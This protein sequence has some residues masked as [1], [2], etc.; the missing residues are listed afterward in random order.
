MIKK[1]ILT[2]VSCLLFGLAIGSPIQADQ[3]ELS[4]ILF[5]RNYNDGVMAVEISLG[6]WE[7]ERHPSYFSYPARIRA[8]QAV[9]ARDP[10]LLDALVR[11]GIEPHNV[12]WVE[13][14][15]NGGRIIYY[16]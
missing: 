7:D 10:L 4:A 15:A 2:A 13:T 16:R 6:H 5:G 3:S 9:V 8:A 14:A 12:L 11:R 1:H